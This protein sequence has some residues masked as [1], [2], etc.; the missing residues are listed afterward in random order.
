MQTALSTLAS[1]Q[2]LLER[3]AAQAEQREQCRA[4]FGRLRN[5]SADDK[6]V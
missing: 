1:T 3:G 5:G 4:T 2:F 6:N